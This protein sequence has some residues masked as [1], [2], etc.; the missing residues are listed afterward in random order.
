M[1]YMN[2]SGKKKMEYTNVLVSL[3]IESINFHQFVMIHAQKK[4]EK[5]YNSKHLICVK[6][7]TLNI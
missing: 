6:K 5:E 3:Y 7:K 4:K 2:V 1:Q